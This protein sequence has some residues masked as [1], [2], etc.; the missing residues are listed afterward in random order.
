MSAAEF[1]VV[2]VLFAAALVAASGSVTV[3]LD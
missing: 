1:V 2:A 3:V